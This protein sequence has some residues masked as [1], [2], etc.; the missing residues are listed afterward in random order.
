[1]TDADLKTYLA[2]IEERAKLKSVMAAV[3]IEMDDEDCRAHGTFDEIEA[4]AGVLGE[5]E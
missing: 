5:A 4:P 2:D 1:M 3:A